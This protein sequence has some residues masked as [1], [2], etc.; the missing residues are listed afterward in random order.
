MLTP[1]GFD[2][3]GGGGGPGPSAAAGNPG[4]PPPAPA[5]A[6][7]LWQPGSLA[8]APADDFEQQLAAAMAASMADQPS[9]AN[10]TPTQPSQLGQ[11]TQPS[12]PGP[13]H[14]ATAWGEDTQAPVPATGV[15]RFATDERFGDQFGSDRFA[16]EAPPMDQQA[17]EQLAGDPAAV[18]ALTA[19]GFTAEQAGRALAA[20]SSDADR[21]A[22]WLFSGG[23]A[24]PPAM[25]PAP[26]PAAAAAVATPGVMPALQMMVRHPTTASRPS[27][28][29]ERSDSCIQHQLI[30]KG[31]IPATQ[32]PLNPP[33][34][35][36][37]GYDPTRCSWWV[38]D[39]GGGPGRPAGGGDAATDRPAWRSD[40]G[41]VPV[42]FLSVLVLC[43]YL[44][45]FL[46]C[47]W[48]VLDL[49]FLCGRSRYRR[50]SPL[51]ARERDW[52][53]E[54]AANCVV[55]CE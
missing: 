8:P 32:R 48:S 7:P 13:L 5:P 22:E 4:A 54:G 52:T 39:Y 42:V 50:R 3:A 12:V 53:S 41:A 43:L 6:G 31:L 44:P 51:C 21:A 2:G 20:N 14:G 25:P 27:R 35:R 24:A 10:A 40:S 17:L 1:P 49:H 30:S 18:A 23:A 38:P 28:R 55:Y 46:V 34:S 15:V 11:P 19:L 16:T 45:L 37:A 33:S 47:S 26:A 29:E 9:A 36:V